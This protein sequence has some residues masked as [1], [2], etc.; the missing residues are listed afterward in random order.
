M[1]TGNSKTNE[2]K[3]FIYQ[4]TEKFNPKSPNKKTIGLVN[5]SI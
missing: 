4:F 3:N 2:S 5:L 1:D